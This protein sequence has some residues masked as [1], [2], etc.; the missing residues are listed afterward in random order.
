MKS[1]LSYTK[2]LDPVKNLTM[3]LIKPYKRRICLASKNDENT[4]LV[5]KHQK[6]MK[7]QMKNQIVHCHIV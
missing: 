4:P 2:V 7:N 6:H 1:D 3:N 5:W